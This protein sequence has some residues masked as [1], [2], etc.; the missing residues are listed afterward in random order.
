MDL[1][2]LKASPRQ[3]RLHDELLQL[4]QL[5]RREVS[6]KRLASAS[7]PPVAPACS[8]PGV[9]T[10]TWEVRVTA[11]RIPGSPRLSPTG[12]LPAHPPLHAFPATVPPV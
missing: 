10:G 5:L 7:T 6:L 12:P 2:S 1:Q 11:A 9:G 8:L 4:C 3:V